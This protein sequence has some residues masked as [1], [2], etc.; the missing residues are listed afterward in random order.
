MKIVH[1]IIIK[2]AKIIYIFSFKYMSKFYMYILSFKSYFLVTSLVKVVF[3][4]S[5]IIL[6]LEFK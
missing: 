6:E 3:D 4:K 2:Y 5:Q 1:K